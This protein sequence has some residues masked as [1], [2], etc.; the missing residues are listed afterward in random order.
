VDTRELSKCQ[1]FLFIHQIE[2]LSQLPVLN[3]LADNAAKLGDEP[4]AEFIEVP[5]DEIIFQYFLFG[6][7]L[8]RGAEFGA[9]CHETARKG[10]AGPHSCPAPTATQSNGSPNNVIGY[11][12]KVLLQPVQ[13]AS[14]ST[15][16]RSALV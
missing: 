11:E 1:T 15:E 16:I 13:N 6:E 5:A 7:F 10:A 12:V 8:G 9:Q 2:R 4:I 3:V 14:A